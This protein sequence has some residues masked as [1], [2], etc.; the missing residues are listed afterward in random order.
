[1]KYQV[2]QAVEDGWGCVDHEIIFE[3][4]DLEEARQVIDEI[5]HDDFYIEPEDLW[6]EDDDGNV[7]D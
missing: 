4:D 5:I 3:T 7:I 1:M 2:W 6:I